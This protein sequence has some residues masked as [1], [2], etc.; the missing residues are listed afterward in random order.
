MS[1]PKSRA[2]EDDRTQLIASILSLNYPYKNE[3]FDSQN[4]CR[5]NNRKG[6]LEVH[7]DKMPTLYDICFVQNLWEYFSENW[8][9]HYFKGEPVIGFTSD[10]KIHINRM[11]VL[12]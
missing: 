7:W 2:C 10:K 4:S 9:T 5:L 1:K 6:E 12:L 8:S 11:S 3:Y